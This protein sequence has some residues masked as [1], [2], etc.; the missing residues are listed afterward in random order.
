MKITNANIF[1]DGKFHNLEV[2][3]NHDKILEIGENLQD[4]FVID[5]DGQYVYAGFV[6]TH[7]HGGF[8]R[9]F[10]ENGHIDF[11]DGEDQI[12]YICKELPK[13]GVTSCVP[14][15]M[16]EVSK[17]PTPLLESTRLIRKVRKD[18][19]GAE[20]FKIHYEGPYLNPL[21]SGCI[22]PAYQVY[23]TIEHTLTMTDND[24]SDV[25]II[26]VSPELPGALE[27]ID[28][29]TKQGIHTEV[30]Y[31][32][33]SSDLVYK[34]ADRG[35]NQV[36]H[37]YNGFEPL[38][39]RTN[40]PI[41]ACLLDERINAQILCDNIH[42]ASEWVKLAIRSKGLDKL[43]GITDMTCFSGLSQGEHDFPY[44]GKIII[45]G[46]KVYDSDGTIAGSN[47]TWDA[48]MRSARDHIGLTM[49]EIGSLYGE[50]PAKCLNIR[51]R[52]KIEV[53]RLPDFTIMDKDY[54]VLKT[55]IHGEVYFE[56]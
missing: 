3:F 1:I 20:P 34:A 14:T 15:L 22:N 38:H 54:N 53:G 17:D 11:S 5:A 18:V 25:L 31:T 16:G 4:D 55:I 42:V 43:Y 45:D 27:Y 13:H 37:L 49:E 39:H 21:R 7:I 6:D 23:P 36:S 41:V 26:C 33:A 35:L 19:V 56:K 51:D 30:C 52:G 9:S 12:R 8:T 10:F 48:M 29:A 24:I 50:N 32:L 40:G 2:K 44:Y 46:A 28:W 47:L